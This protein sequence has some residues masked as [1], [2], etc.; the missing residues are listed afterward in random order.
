MINNLFFKMILIKLIRDEL[1]CDL[2]VS[3]GTPQRADVANA[4][5]APGRGGA[6]GHVLPDRHQRTGRDQTGNRPL[7]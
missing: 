5:A 1:T 6:A 4:N 7:L 3:S 2:C